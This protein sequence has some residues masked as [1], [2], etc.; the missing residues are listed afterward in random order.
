MDYW[1]DMKISPYQPPD[2]NFNSIQLCNLINS[3]AIWHGFAKERSAR[4]YPRS[5]E[6]D[7]AFTWNNGMMGIKTEKI[8][9]YL[10]PIFCFN[11]FRIISLIIP[12]P[13]YGSLEISS[14]ERGGHILIKFNKRI[15][16]GNY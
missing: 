10:F 11:L 2:Y 15:D 16:F 6:A 9:F 4:Y 12:A 1:K 7:W 13:P 14:K 8:V 5:D 3:K